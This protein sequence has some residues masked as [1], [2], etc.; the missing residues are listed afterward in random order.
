MKIEWQLESNKAKMEYK[1]DLM[2]DTDIFVPDNI[3]Y[4]FNITMRSGNETVAIKPKL[5]LGDVEI[6]LVP[7]KLSSGVTV[8]TSKINHSFFDNA[9]FFN[10]FGESELLLM[11][12]QNEELVEYTK[13]INVTLRNEKAKIAYDMLNYLSDNLEDISQVC[14]SKTRSG[15]K[16]KS[17]GHNNMVKIENLNKTINF[18][19]SYVDKFS[20]NKKCQLQKNMIIRSDQFPVYDYDTTNWLTSN[21]DKL[22]P[23]RKQDYTIAINK[24]YYHVDLPINNYSSNTNQKEN[25]AI[26][27][28]ILSGIEYCSYMVEVFKL[29]ENSHMSSY[30]NSEYI[31]FDQVIKNSINPILRSKLN[32]IIDTKNRLIQ[33]KR[34]YDNVI[35]VKNLKATLPIQTSFTLKNKHYS[36][37]FNLIKIFYESNHV[38]RSEDINILL[39]MRNLSQIYEFF[40]CIK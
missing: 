20:R 19:E 40:V 35:P 8:F 7:N 37:A 5:F 12:Y 23:A 9:H 16:P 24:N 14:F 13:I 33:L 32:K 11:T 17:D 36:A 25:R 22:R 27:W 21:F 1:H 2:S 15:F 18:L 28:F 38:D 31:R 29:Q 4:I 30:E 26:H 3:E 10:Y 6:K 39:G 34:I